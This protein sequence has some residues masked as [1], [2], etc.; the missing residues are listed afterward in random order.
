MLRNV[1]IDRL[2]KPK[3]LPLEQS[4]S[5][6][7]KVKAFT[8]KDMDKFESLLT[9]GLTDVQRRIYS[10]VTHDGKEYDLIAETLGIS[11]EAVR[12]HMSRARTK[13]RENYKKIDK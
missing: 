9:T 7:L 10:L 12:M 4:D 13:I 11:V 8:F 3:T 6:R 1:C 5:D 2:R